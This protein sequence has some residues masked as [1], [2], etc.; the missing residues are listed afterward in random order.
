MGALGCWGPSMPTSVA[1]CL[2][3]VEGQTGG[4]LVTYKSN[5]KEDEAHWCGM[6]RAAL[7]P[8]QDSTGGCSSS[9]NPAGPKP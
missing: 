1:M 7:L 6:S 3:Q 9:R 2:L 4:K 5:P 8:W